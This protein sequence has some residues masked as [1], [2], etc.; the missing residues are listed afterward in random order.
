MSSHHLEQLNRDFESFYE[1]C[2]ENNLSDDDIRKICQP[3]IQHVRKAKLVKHVKICILAMFLL[4]TLYVICTTETASWHLAA[5]GRIFMIKLLPLYDW[6][7][8]RHENCLIKKPSDEPAKT[9]FDC[10][11][12][13]SIANIEKIPDESASAIYE[14]NVKLHVPFIVPRGL[15]WNI[16]GLP[17][18]NLTLLLRN[19]PVLSESY[20]CKLSTNVHN[21]EDSLGNVLGALDHFRRYFIHFQNC[22][23]RAVKQFRIFAPRPP[24]L[25][26]HMGPVQYS[27]MLLNRDYNVTRFKRIALRE[28]VA[29]AAQIL[30]RTE[31]RLTPQAE[32]EFDCG[33]LEDVLDE[34]ELLVVTALWDLEYRPVARGENAAVVLEARRP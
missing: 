7:Q 27:W 20:P 4:L 32:C 18:E 6:T 19:D 26:R 14:R 23:W 8:L 10:V 12:C 29:V 17:L 16:T 11:L 30:G 1:F 31:F 25:Q 2:K 22:E 28:S 24:F 9:Q 33:V 13:E 34:G 21:G 15:Q 5:I 3:L